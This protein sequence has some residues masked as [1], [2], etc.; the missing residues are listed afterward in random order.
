MFPSDGRWWPR[1]VSAGIRETARQSGG[2]NF[3]DRRVR[4]R[5]KGTALLDMFL[6]D[7][8]GVCEER[9]TEHIR[10][11]ERNDPFVGCAC[12]EKGLESIA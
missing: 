3:T 6:G 9:A 7:E 4:N 10:I 11:V 5:Y 2:A 1:Q 12:G 8:L